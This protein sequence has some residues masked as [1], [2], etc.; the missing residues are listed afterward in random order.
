[1]PNKSGNA[2]GLTILCPLKA[3]DSKGQSVKLKLRK[4]LLA[5]NDL[6][7]SPMSKVPNTYLSRFYILED[8]FFQDYP[9]Q[10]EHLQSAY[11]VC[12]F[13]LHGDLDTYLE[14]MYN[15]I[16]SD[17]HSIWEDA[18]GFET[19]KMNA[20]EFKKYIKKCQ[21]ETTFYFDGST[22]DSLEEQLKSLYIK[23]EFSKFVFKNAYKPAE[24]LQAAFKEF[25]KT[26]KPFEALPT[27]YA[28]VEDLEK[29][30]RTK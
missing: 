30:V 2:Y 9:H 20:S 11:L 27:W 17:I 10:E 14:R 12:T 22:D 21:V 29:V 18:Y 24:E 28:G 8:V 6:E 26:S 19:S 13:D 1:M 5:L 15:A 3:N 25:T 7:N 4:K 23:Q 16:S